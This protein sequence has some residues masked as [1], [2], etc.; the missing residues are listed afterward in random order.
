MPV[1]L[2]HET[3][4]FGVKIP[5]KMFELP[6]P[7]VVV[8]WCRMASESQLG[9]RRKLVEVALAYEDEVVAAFRLVFFN[10]V[11]RFFAWCDFFGVCFFFLS[12]GVSASKKT[13]SLELKHQDVEESLW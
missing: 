9:P 4:G 2:D 11:G 8:V 13:V 1:K 10:F 6:S 3:P 5:K 12:F 7:T